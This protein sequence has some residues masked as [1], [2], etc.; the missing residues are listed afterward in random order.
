MSYNVFGAVFTYFWGVYNAKSVGFWG[1]APGPAGGAYSPP[2]APSPGWLRLLICPT[3][4]HTLTFAPPPRSQFLDP[5]LAT[6]LRIYPRKVGKLKRPRTLPSA[7]RRLI[8]T[9][10]RVGVDRPVVIT[11]EIWKEQLSD[12]KLLASDNY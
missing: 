9:Y 7:P 2:P 11:Q 8:K 4:C 12:H 3:P 10:V 5:P 6:V 1:Y